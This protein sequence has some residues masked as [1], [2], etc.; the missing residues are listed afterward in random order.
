MTL[1]FGVTGSTD[2]GLVQRIAPKVEEAGFS[3]FWSNDI[4]GGSSFDVLAAAAGVTREINLANGVVP[5]DRVPADLWKDR[6]ERAGL[7]PDRYHAGI[8][9]GQLK[10]PLEPVRE[11]IETITRETGCRVIVGALRARMRRLAAEHA[12]GVLL[13]WLTAEAAADRRDEMRAIRQETGISEP[14]LAAAFVR[15]AIGDAAIARLRDEAS[16]YESYPSYGKHFTEMGVGAFD[17]AVSASSVEEAADGL[18]PF[19]GALDHTVLRCV[20]AEETDDE[21]LRLIEA[22]RLALERAGSV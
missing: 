18:I 19:F 2:A 22:G 9:S 5:I 3:F 17:T 1:G 6:V 21:Y 13:N 4:P 10:A 16:R 11:A 7:A 14:F 8:G 15:V 20:V 12:D